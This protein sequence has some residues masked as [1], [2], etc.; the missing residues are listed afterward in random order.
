MRL[1][2]ASIAFSIALTMSIGIG[3]SSTSNSDVLTI[4]QEQLTTDQKTIHHLT[5]DTPIKPDV[6][7]YYDY[8]KQD[9]MPRQFLIFRGDVIA[10]VMPQRKDIII[11]KDT[12]VKASLNGVDAMA[13]SIPND[14]LV[15]KFL[16]YHG[17][18]G[19]IFYFDGDEMPSTYSVLL[20]NYLGRMAQSFVEDREFDD[21]VWGDTREHPPLKHSDDI[22]MLDVTTGKFYP[23]EIVLGEDELISIIVNVDSGKTT[24]CGFNHSVAQLLGANEEHFDLFL[25]DSKV[26][27]QLKLS[28]SHF[29]HTETGCFSPVLHFRTKNFKPGAKTLTIEFNGKPLTY[30]VQ[31]TVMGNSSFKLALGN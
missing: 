9:L 20:T 13:Y 1:F 21:E 2:H 5:S 19:L 17:D 23:N 12:P 18:A 10:V 4:D 14:K 16:D 28:D 31:T 29:M 25:E 15:D 3:C 26:Q 22:I 7:L 8:E 24:I 6:I 30:L 11:N 27:K